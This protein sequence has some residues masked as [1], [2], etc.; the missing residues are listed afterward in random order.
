MTTDAVPETDEESEP[1]A[2]N[3]SADG[4]ETPSGDQGETATVGPP[5]SGAAFLGLR[6][7]DRSTRILVTAAFFAAVQ[8]ALL[9]QMLSRQY[10]L[11][12][13][14]D[15]EH[16]AHLHRL[17]WQY[18]MTPHNG[19]LMPGG[20]AIAW[21]VTRISPMN[22]TLAA[23]SIVLMQALASFAVLRLLR[24]LFGTRPAILVLFVFYL[25]SAGNLPVGG[26]WAPALEVLPL[27]TM[28]AL[29]LGSHILYLRRGERRDARLTILF[30][31]LGLLFMAKAIA[32]PPLLFAFTVYYFSDQPT[33]RLATVDTLRRYWQIWAF[34]VALLGLYELFYR[35][36]L[37]MVNA[38]ASIPDSISEIWR[39]SEGL[40]G[41]T[42]VSVMFGGPWKWAHDPD[43]Y[44]FAAPPTGLVYVSWIVLI[45]VIATSV[46]F[47]VRA[48]R[49][50]VLL[51]G[52]LIVGDLLPVLLGRI[53]V[54]QPGWASVLST[55]T[56]YIADAT[57]VAACCVGLAFLPMDGETG[58]PYRRPRPTSPRVAGLGQALVGVLAV[59]I[60][61]GLAVS[62]VS[63]HRYVN[64]DADRKWFTNARAA[65]AA[66]TDG[67]S[68]L[69]TAV[70][71]KLNL[72]WDYE[73]ATAS[74]ILGSVS[75]KTQNAEIPISQPVDVAFAFDGNGFLRPVLGV[76]NG[77]SAP[78][79]PVKDYGYCFGDATHPT[80]DIHLPAELDW[81]HWTV[82]MRYLDHDA[83]AL[84]VKYS[85]AERSL[86]LPA[87]GHVVTFNLPGKGSLIELSGITSQHGLCISGLDVGV[88]I[89]G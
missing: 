77:A 85:I 87:G 71:P 22:W 40:V 8:L 47:R 42:F 30:S 61:V 57:I 12:D 11:Q 5:A 19:H 72:P 38:S 41:H 73:K 49:A 25:F 36:R 74:Y 28:L 17:G 31:V 81:S 79:G 39:F 78:P 75:S 7:A 86:Q 4:T 84:R 46:A 32:I 82:R 64:G 59:V 34:Y 89:L 50:W 35:K 88:P 60:P 24:L 54:I 67:S 45:A 1:D 21:V 15:F 53:S 70:P 37:D 18:L 65:L 43:S 13:D 62:V 16:G 26:W 27:E 58:S 33:L 3:Q 29:A 63:Y 20:L 69:D 76:A 23:A 10:F 80:V 6:W 51:G 14:F 2:G 9:G 56:R 48:G 44:A 66:G 68:I 55:E 83:T 52:Y